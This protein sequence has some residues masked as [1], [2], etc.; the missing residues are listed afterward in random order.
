MKMKNINKHI[1]DKATVA[2]RKKVEKMTLKLDR[3]FG[4]GDMY[5]ILTYMGEQPSEEESKKILCNFR[6]R[7]KR[8]FKKENKQFALITVDEHHVGKLYHHII[9]P[10]IDPADLRELWSKGLVYSKYL[11][12]LEYHETLARYLI[13]KAAS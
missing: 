4:A 10:E 6:E 11:D 9:M 3:S 7:L 13:E 1:S 12:G 5:A 8:Y 2:V